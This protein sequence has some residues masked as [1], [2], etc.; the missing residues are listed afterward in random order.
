MQI[1]VF[2]EV[3]HQASDKHSHRC[4][5]EAPLESFRALA[6]THE[7]APKRSDH[8][9]NIDAHIEDCVCGV[10]ARI[11]FR[12][13][14]ADHCRDVGLEETISENQQPKSGK[15]KPISRRRGVD[16]RADKHKKLSE[17]HHCRAEKNRP[18]VAPEAVGKIAAEQRR[19]IHQPGVVAINLGGIFLGKRQ[20][21]KHIEHK[22]CP[23]SIVTEP[24]PHFRQKQHIK[25][26]RVSDIRFFH[27]VYLFDC[28]RRTAI[29]LQKY[30]FFKT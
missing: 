9:T 3:E 14:V 25:P 13:E 29:I 26:F 5:Q 20:A 1:A 18:A 28:C 17:S 6:I 22:H 21:L 24:F 15:H 2:E 30:T 27:I 23:H 10:A 8:R 12:I 11:V 4:R 7:S 16:A 19:Q